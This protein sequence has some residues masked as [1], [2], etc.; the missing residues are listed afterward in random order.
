MAMFATLLIA[1]LQASDRAAPSTLAGELQAFASPSWHRVG[2]A[3]GKLES[4][5]AAA[6]P[7]LIE[8]AF[9]EDR[10]ALQDTFDL[11]YPGA[12][13]FYGHGYI[14][15][16]DLDRLSARAGWLL[17]EVTFQDF[18]FAAS[19]ISK[20]QLLEQT[21]KGKRDVPFSEVVPTTG[22]PSGAKPSGTRAAAERARK[23]WQANSK[24]WNRF[25]ALKEALRSDNSARQVKALGWLRYGTTAC[26]SL[27]PARYQKEL[28]PL[29]EIVARKGSPA[30][31][32]Q[33]KYL[34]DDSEN[35]WWRYK[36]GKF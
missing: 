19:L 9:R 12:T 5:Q 16:Y 30:A 23:W 35:F 8:M 33:A 24:T 18:G 29:V 3:K 1:F 36:T 15:D 34:L 22:K 11:I 26:E 25:D 10:V 13:K 28:R 32:E 14:V 2:Q 17:E 7:A 31:R 6:I 21:L 4:R 20:Q 27:S